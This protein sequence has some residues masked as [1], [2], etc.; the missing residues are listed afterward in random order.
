MKST[1]KPRIA[2]DMTMLKYPYTGLGQFSLYLGKEL[3]SHHSQDATYDFLLYPQKEDFF[4]PL[5]YKPQ[6]LSWWQRLLGKNKLPYLFQNYALWHILSQNSRYFP[7][8]TKAPI[9]YTIHDLNFLKE[10]SPNRAQQRLKV[11]AQQIQK[12]TAVV[13]ISQ[14]AADDIAKHIDLGNKK[15]QVIHNGVAMKHF[16]RPAR[17]TFMPTEAASKPFLYTVGFV[18][19]RKNVHVLV[20]MMQHLPQYN[21]VIAGKKNDADYL[22]KI[23]ELIQKYGLA[24]QIIMPD[25]ISDEE[26]FWL[27]QNCEAL[28]FPS[29]LEGFGMPLIEALSMQKTV[30][31]SHLTSLPEVGGEIAHYWHHFEPHYMAQVLREGIEKNKQDTSYGQKALAQAQKFTWQVA[32]QKYKDLYT[33]MIQ[34]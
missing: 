26:K 8:N 33:Q 3:L 28:V 30:F 2:L 7:Y 25:F 13:A 22:A 9:V 18:S 14:Y 10:D 1:A 6:I 5:P 34:A 32:A 4:A 11:V 12:S 17:P 20:E 27:Y 31:A 15:I 19:R 29:L 16:D 24:T 21:L 23:Q